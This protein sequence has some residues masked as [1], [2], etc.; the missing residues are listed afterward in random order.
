[1]EFDE[2]VLKEQDVLSTTA[3]R[4]KFLAL[5]H[6]DSTHLCY[7]IYHIELRHQVAEL[8]SDESVSKVA[9]PFEY[10]KMFVSLVENASS[11]HG[12]D[13]LIYVTDQGEPIRIKAAVRNANHIVVPSLGC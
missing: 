5:I 9:G 10:W 3:S 8:W 4:G 12:E 7:F 2:I 1:M 13:C 11:V 6:D